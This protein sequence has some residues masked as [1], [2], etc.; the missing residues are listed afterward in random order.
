MKNLFKS[1]IAPLRR[2][3]LLVTP[4]VSVSKKSLILKCYK[5]KNNLSFLAPI[6]DVYGNPTY[7][8]LY[9]CFSQKNGTIKWGTS[10]INDALQLKKLIKNRIKLLIKKTKEKIAK[11]KKMGN[12]NN[13]PL[14]GKHKQDAKKFIKAPPMF[15]IYYR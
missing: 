14:F 13:V 12:M 7:D 4:D 10:N 5:N 1:I 11:D 9:D 15:R 6:F 8:C 2:K 3:L